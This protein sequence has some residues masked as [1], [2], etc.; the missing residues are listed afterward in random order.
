MIKIKIGEILNAQNSLTTLQGQKLNIKTAYKLSKLIKIVIAELDI[1]REN[2]VK[3]L[4]RYADKDEVGE[5]IIINHKYQIDD[6]DNF[7]K[8]YQDLVNIEINIDIEPFTFNDLLEITFTA[9]DMLLLEK[10]IV[11]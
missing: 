7:N 4:D 10:F 2:H 5:F 3:L 6:L 11:E 9:Q 1:F 8:E